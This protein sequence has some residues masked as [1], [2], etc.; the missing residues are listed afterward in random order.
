MIDDIISNKSFEI[1][2][3]NTDNKIKENNQF[4]CCMLC[5][6]FFTCISKCI[7]ICSRG[8]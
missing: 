8:Y 4:T 6:D 5:F 2:E 7:F 3:N 1:I